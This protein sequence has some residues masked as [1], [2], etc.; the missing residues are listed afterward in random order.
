MLSQLEQ[1]DATWKSF[2]Y[3]LPMGTMKCLL[4]S[5]IDTLPTKVDLKLLEKVSNDKCRCDRREVLNYI[6]NCFDQSLKEGKY[7]YT[8]FEDVPSCQTPG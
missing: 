2:V 8:C 3:N 7:K 6:L 1:N 4:N 5:A